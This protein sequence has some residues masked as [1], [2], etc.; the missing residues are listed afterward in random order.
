MFPPERRFASL[1]TGGFS[2]TLGGYLASVDLTASGMIALPG[3]AEPNSGATDGEARQAFGRGVLHHPGG[4]AHGARVPRRHHRQLRSR[5]NSMVT[6]LSRA[7]LSTY[8]H[9]FAARPQE[10]HAGALALSLLASLSLGRSRWA[11]ASARPRSGGAPG[12][13]SGSTTRPASRCMTNGW[14]SPRPSTSIEPDSF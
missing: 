4:Q 11:T 3:F 6:A 2:A 9:R 10:A 12:C 13:G 7:E 5:R 1:S 8:P 14:S